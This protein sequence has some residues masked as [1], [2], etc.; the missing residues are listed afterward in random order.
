MNEHFQSVDLSKA[1]RLVNHGPTVLIS[2]R[3]GGVENVMTAAWCCGLDF[4]PPKLTVVIDKIAH[5]RRLIESSGH[6]MV[7]I[8]TVDQLTLAQTLGTRSMHDNPD[9]LIAAGVKLFDVP[10]H[11]LPFVECCSAWLECQLVSEPHIQDAYDLFVG[12]VSAAW[13]DDRVFRHG[14]WHFETADPKWR[15]IHHVAGGHYYAIGEAMSAG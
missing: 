5:T 8:P 4:E 12:Q 11:D 2:A 15:T 6:F 1:Y 14:R 3:H 10:G 7:Q 9:K 13:A